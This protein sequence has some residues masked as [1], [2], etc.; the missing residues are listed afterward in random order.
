MNGAG[1][2]TRRRALST[3]GAAGTIQLLAACGG[4]P[5]QETSTALTNAPVTIQYYKRGTL[6]DA[7]VEALLK[8]WTA[9][10]PTWKVE[11]VQGVTDEKLAAH[12]AADDKMDT[13]TY[14]YAARTMILAYNMLRPIDSFVSKDRYAV[15]KFSAKEV[16]L[17]GR[18]DG[19]LWALPYAYGGNA[20]ALFY[21]RNMF[22][23]A[24]VPEPAADW[25]QAWTFDQFR[26]NARK[27][28]KRNGGSITQVAINGL[29]DAPNNTLTSLGVL[30]DA[31]VISDDYTK[32]ML[33]RTETIDVF[34]RYADLILKDLVTTSS[35]GADLGSGNAFLN[36]KQAMHVICCGPLAFVRQI[37]PTGIDWGFAPM[38]KIKYSSPDFQSVLTLLPKSSQNPDHGWELFKYLIE[39]ARL[40]TVEERVPG[41]LEDAGD[42]AKTSFAEYPNARA[43]VLVDGIKFARPVD[44]V[45]YHPA[46][47]ELYTTARPLVEGMYAGKETVK[48]AFTTLHQQFQAILDRTPSGR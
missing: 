2:T 39:D 14:N 25:N 45:K 18:Y 5:V 1:S 3:A 7:N 32:S 40:G 48:Q 15:G 13:L 37:K 6:A 46:S 20:T 41:V 11:L 8:D 21:N 38:P 12:V 17:V 36:G 43:Q 44:K 27:L 22:K 29:S 28:T 42:W 4:Q 47:A 35:P 10:H 31:K 23:E 19:K 26:D 33:D 30:S 9:Q 24:G 16:D 34:Q